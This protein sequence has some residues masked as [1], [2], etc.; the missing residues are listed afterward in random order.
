MELRCLKMLFLKTW[1]KSHWY[2]N[3][4]CMD[5]REMTC[6]AKSRA[7][8]SVPSYLI[9]SHE[10][11]IDVISGWVRVQRVLVFHNFFHY[12]LSQLFNVSRHFVLLTW[13]PFHQ[14]REDI[15]QLW[16]GAE[17]TCVNNV[18]HSRYLP[19]FC[20]CGAAQIKMHNLSMHTNCK[21]RTNGTKYLLKSF[22]TLVITSLL[23]MTS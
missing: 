21:T 20:I 11:A 22:W 2:D 13:Q 1:N 14:P 10:E 18:F 6:A 19:N 16:W 17:R 12:K 4:T 3:T 9:E 8:G 5:P 7:L 15:I 23:C